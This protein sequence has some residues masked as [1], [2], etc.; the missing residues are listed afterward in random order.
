MDT[1]L[2]FYMGMKRIREIVRGL[3]LNGK[4][5]DTP[6]AI[7]QNATLVNQAIFTSTLKNIHADIDKIR[8]HTPS[9]IIIGDV[10]SYYSKFRECLDILPSQ[11]VES[12]GDLGFDIWKNQAV[13]A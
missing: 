1:T 6:I 12:F 8:H 4:S 5:E 13:T 2:V 7:V 10:V 11:M 9:I 3:I